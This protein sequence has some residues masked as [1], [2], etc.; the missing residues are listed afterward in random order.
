MRRVRLG[1]WSAIVVG[2]L[3]AA[4]S[5]AAEPLERRTVELPEP[6]SLPRLERFVSR[7]EYEAAQRA[8]D[9]RLERITY[10]SDS[11]DVAAYVAT[12]VPPQPHAPLVLF[13]RGSYVVGDIA[14]Q[15]APMLH[16]LTRAGFAVVVPLLRGSDGAAGHD[17][18]GGA[19]LADF[20]G[21][22]AAARELRVTDSRELH[23]YG[24]SRGGMMVYQALRDGIDARSAVTF[25]AFTDLDSLLV[26]D[27]ERSGRMPPVVW[28][29]WPSGRDSIAARR[30]AMRWPERLR[31]P[32][33]LLHGAEDG[34]VPPRQS[35]AL[36]DTLRALRRPCERIV[37]AG[38]S[39]TL[40]EVAARRDSLAVDWFRRNAS[41]Q[42]RAR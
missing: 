38:A 41:A 20:T 10:R 33:L 13:G 21:A 11:L 18:M 4:A 31:T 30:S 22:V 6:D 1:G 37:L 3:V 36:H 26:A 35:Q 15:L 8:T 28:P 23:L 24:E 14:W 34:S 25:G 16:R 42:P 2:C 32:L 7:P 39:H 5:W 40:R 9:W 27:P 19:E 12:A 29:Q 17:E